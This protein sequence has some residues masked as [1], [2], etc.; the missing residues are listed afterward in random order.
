VPQGDGV[1]IYRMLSNPRVPKIMLPYSLCSTSERPIAVLASTTVLGKATSATP[2]ALFSV[3]PAGGGAW[4]GCERQVGVQST[5]CV[6]SFSLNL[7]VRS[8]LG[9]SNPQDSTGGSSI[10]M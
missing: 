10:Y 7:S 5:N 4:R 6:C 9:Q 2:Q 8:Q 3:Q 1:V